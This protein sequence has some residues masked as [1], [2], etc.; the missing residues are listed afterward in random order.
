MLVET[1]DIAIVGNTLARYLYI[2]RMP[3]VSKSSETK[4]VS[5]QEIIVTIIAVFDRENNDD[6]KKQIENIVSEKVKKIRKITIAL[7]F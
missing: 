3:F 2:G 7:D 6:K 1:N 4:N 5:Q